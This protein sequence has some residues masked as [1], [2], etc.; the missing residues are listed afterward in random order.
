MVSEKP[1]HAVSAGNDKIIDAQKS[2]WH[3]KEAKLDL[4]TAKME[5]RRQGEGDPGHR[6]P[7]SLRPGQHRDDAEGSERE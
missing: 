3:A 6:R 2:V 1:V 5:L 4:D 7:D